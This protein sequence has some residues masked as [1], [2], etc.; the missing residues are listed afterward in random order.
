MRAA[1]SACSVSGTRSDEPSPDPLSRSIRIVSSTK[2]GLPSARS[3]ASLGQRRRRSPAAPASWS[4]SCSTSSV[5]LLLR[6]RLE[7]DRG[8]AHAPSTP[9]RPRVEQLGACEADDEERRAHPVGEVLDQVEERLPRP[10]GCPRRG[11][12]AAARRRSPA[13]PRA[14]PRRSPAGCARPRAP[15]SA[16]RRARERPPRPPRRSTRE[17][18]RTPPRA[19]RRRRCRPPP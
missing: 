14:P 3:S 10:S 5:A 12:S 9:A 4:R 15:P 2:S 18:S 17:A 11:G 8:R 1:M 13:S 7:L 6:E 16:R 19:D